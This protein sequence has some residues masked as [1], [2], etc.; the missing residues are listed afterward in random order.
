RIWH[1]LAE[2]KA[3]LFVKRHMRMLLFTSLMVL[4][5]MTF[6]SIWFNIMLAAPKTADEVKV[7]FAVETGLTTKELANKLH[8]AGL[9]KSPLAFNVYAKMHGYDVKIKSGKYL[10]S[11][12]M[13]SQEI[14]EKL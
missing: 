8:E 13:S 5:V 6:P 3:Y 2:S 10:I 11:P 1:V 9:I 4:C 7:Q 14:I 12:S